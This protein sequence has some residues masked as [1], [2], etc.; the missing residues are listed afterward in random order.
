MN[1]EAFFEISD[2]NGGLEEG[3]GT[4]GDGLELYPTLHSESKSGLP[5][6]LSLP[7]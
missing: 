4:G 5:S 6:S 3:E 2:N 7:T 1:S